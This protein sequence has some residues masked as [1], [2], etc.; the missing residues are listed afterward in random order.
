[1]A[2]IWNPKTIDDAKVVRPRDDRPFQK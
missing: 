1:M 2:R